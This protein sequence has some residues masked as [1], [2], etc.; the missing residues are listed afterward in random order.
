MISSITIV[1]KA[2]ISP[3]EPTTEK[4][5]TLITCYPFFFV[6]HAPKRFIVK[7]SPKLSLAEAR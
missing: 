1:D 7:A 5:L 4:T 3:L 2:D 6:G